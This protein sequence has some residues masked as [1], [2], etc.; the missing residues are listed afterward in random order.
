MLLFKFNDVTAIVEKKKYK[1][2]EKSIN[3]LKGK[4][5]F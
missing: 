1:E 3:F 2:T 4:C 5:F